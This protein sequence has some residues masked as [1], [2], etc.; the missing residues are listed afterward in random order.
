M[1]QTIFLEFDEKG[2]FNFEEPKFVLMWDSKLKIDDANVTIQLD[3]VTQKDRHFILSFKTMYANNYCLYILDHRTFKIIY[4]HDHYQLWESPSCGFLNTCTNDFVCL[5]KNGMSFIPVGQTNKMRVIDY[6]VDGT[7]RMVH[8]L[9]SCD[10]LKI[11]PNNMIY[12]EKPVFGSRGRKLFIQEQ[13][14]SKEGYTEYKEV[15]VISVDE[16]ALRELVMISSIFKLQTAFQV[17]DLI[18]QQPD[19][20]LYFKSF[21]ELDKANLISIFSCSSLVIRE[22]MSNKH[23]AKIDYPIFYKIKQDLELE[24]GEDEPK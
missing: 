18:R 17:I 23:K 24:E 13:M 8:P 11:E 3:Q 22:L 10:Y 19:L 2:I 6:A 15:L 16:T 12:F 14:V 20:T 4:R 21:M 1:I 5:N 9:C 7:K